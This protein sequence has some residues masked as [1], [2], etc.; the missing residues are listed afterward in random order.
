[1]RREIDKGFLY[2]NAH[3]GG[4]NLKDVSVGGRLIL[5]GISV[6]YG[7]TVKDTFMSP[8]IGSFG[9]RAQREIS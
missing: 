1:M 4:D 7:R 8:R 6:K 3:D 9:Y 2:E 5:K